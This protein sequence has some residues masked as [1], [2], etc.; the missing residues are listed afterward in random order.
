MTETIQAPAPAAGDQSGNAPIAPAAPAAPAAS[1]HPRQTLAAA[2]AAASAPASAQGILAAS[3]AG[4]TYQVVAGD[5]GASIANRLGITF[6]QLAA[7]NPGVNW[8]NLQIGQS[9]NI[10]GAGGGGGVQRYSVVA[11]DTGFAIAQRFGVTFDQLSAANPGVNWNNLSIGQVLN[12]PTGQ[13]G[14]G[15]ASGGGGAPPVSNDDPG[16]IGGGPVVYYSGPASNFPNPAN[17]Q[18]WSLMWA[19]NS[20]IMRINDSPQEVAWMEQAINQVGGDTRI[21][22]RVILAMIMQESQGN[23]RVNTT[24]SADGVRNAGIL[25]SH[26]GV[27]FDPNNPK[28]SI[29]QMVRDGIQ[30]T[31]FGD[32]LVQLLARYGNVYAAF[33]GYN[34]GSVDPNNLSYGFS[35]TPNYVSD[36]ANRLMGAPPN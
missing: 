30:G 3:A 32:G 15:G 23:V 33:R 29:L 7:A 12:I 22:R 9:L 6:D 34:S 26:N 28:G 24:Y 2:A 11:G 31:P 8:N 13:R 21:D 36:I 4:R 1:N 25:Q 27:S 10:P 35:S 14:G 5:T 18:R 17:W 20:T 16:T 19:R